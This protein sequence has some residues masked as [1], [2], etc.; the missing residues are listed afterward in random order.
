MLQLRRGEPESFQGVQIHKDKAQ[1]MK[2][3]QEEMSS[4]K[5]NNTY[6]LV[7]LPKG[8]KP[9]KNKWVYKLKTDGDKL[10]KH[11]ARLVVNGFNQK[12]GIDFDDI[13]SPVVKMSSIRVI[14]GLTA[15]LDLELEQLDVKTAF[16]HGDL[17]E[18]IYM[19]QP[20]GFEVTGKTHLVCK[21]KKSLYGLKQA[22]RQWY[23]KFD[24]FMMGQEYTRTDADH[25][26]YFK[27]FSD[28]KLVILSLYV[29]DMLIVGHDVSLIENLKKELSS[30]F[31]MKD[32]GPAKQILGMQIICDRRS[33]KLWVSQEK[34]VEQVLSRSI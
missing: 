14:L 18:E 22:P 33:K 4:L 25:C 2:A 6:E 24:S 10:V 7:E 3:M 5:K 31:D 15:S 19:D 29:D 20:E 27:K 30:S 26:V 23:K 9:L 12:K 13:F 17:E 28:G 34:Y 32:L 21:L 11:K 8:R 16:L 1:W